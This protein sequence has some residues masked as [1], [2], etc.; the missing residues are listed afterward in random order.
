MK[1]WES[2]IRKVEPY[3]PGELVPF[4]KEFEKYL[5]SLFDGREIK[6]FG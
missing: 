3:V 4:D 5:P 6:K 1:V 2:Y